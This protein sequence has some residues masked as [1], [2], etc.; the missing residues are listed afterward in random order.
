[1]DA[2]RW[3]SF[4]M[5][6]TAVLRWNDSCDFRVGFTVRTVLVGVKC[7]TG[8]GMIGGMNTNSGTLRAGVPFILTLFRA[9]GAPGAPAGI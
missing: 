8:S 2:S 4:G 7:L 1:M 9:G 3:L 5:R 6:L